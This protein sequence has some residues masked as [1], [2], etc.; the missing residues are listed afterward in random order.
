MNILAMDP[1]SQTTGFFLY[2][3]DVKPY[4][5]QLSPDRAFE[6]LH[7]THNVFAIVVEKYRP[8]G[9]SDSLPAELNGAA[10]LTAMRLDAEYAEVTPAEAKTIAP[11][12]VLK[13]LG[14]YDA[15]L[16]HANDA[17]RLLVHFALTRMDPISS[18]HNHVVDV[19]L[20]VQL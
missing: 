17:A 18:L 16:P 19:K 15:S 10:R 9:T 5:F 6:T 2:S 7:Y 13:A 12:H 14:W 8:K 3:T 4:L 1:G 20:A 11:D